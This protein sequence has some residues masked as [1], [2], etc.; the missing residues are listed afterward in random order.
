MGNLLS[1]SGYFALFLLIEHIL[2]AI[3][4]VSIYIYRVILMSLGCIAC[5][6]VPAADAQRISDWKTL[7]AELEGFANETTGGLGGTEYEVTNAQD[8][9]THDQKIPGTLRYAIEHSALSPLWITFRL[10]IGTTIVLKRPLPLRS[11]LTID[12]RGSDIR[13]ANRVDWSQYEIDTNKTQGRQQCR[14]INRS[15][16]KGTLLSINRQQNIIV[17]HLTFTR[18]GFKNSPWENR[19]PDL[20]KEC[21]GDVLSIYNDAK[22]F[23]S[24]VDRIWINRS[25]FQECGDGC[26]DVTRPDTQVSRISI[27]NN[28]FRNTDKTMIIGTPYDAYARPDPISRRL[29]TNVLPGSYPYHVSLYGNRFENVNERNPRISHALVH[30][31]RNHYINWHLYAVYVEDAMLFYER[32]IHENSNPSTKVVSKFSNGHILSRGNTGPNGEPLAE[33]P[34]SPDYITI[35]DQYGIPTPRSGL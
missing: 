2:A 20:D 3:R 8:Y 13:I 15:V 10:P 34:D 21:L 1:Q 26:I 33:L 6:N 30:I 35:R 23:G 9:D 28:I 32:N 7:L 16:P 24:N 31:Y 17:T 12:G 19:I 5:L 14:K 4:N 11:N 29:E 22:S 18:I 27:S 25:T